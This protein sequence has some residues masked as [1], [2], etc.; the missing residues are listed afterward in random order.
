[1]SNADNA[2]TSS[3]VN[4]QDATNATVPTGSQVS[5][6]PRSGLPPFP[7]FDPHQDRATVGQRWTQWVRRF[8]NLL[9]SLR[10]F[11]PTIRRGLLLTYV[12][13][14]TN[15]IFD[16][17]PNTGT[18]YQS[19]IDSLSQHFNPQANKDMAIF[20]FREL[21]QGQNETLNE[22]YRRLKIKAVHCAFH[23]EEAELKTQIIHKTRDTRLRKKAL[24][25]TMSLQEILDYGNTLE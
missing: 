11:D 24:R 18:T 16:I 1:M 2:S 12:G 6:M 3:N 7:A 14:S 20:D 8:E 23:N 22:Y 17:L 13:E 15:D 9:I 4:A 19:A 5:P 25:E 10:E 21:S